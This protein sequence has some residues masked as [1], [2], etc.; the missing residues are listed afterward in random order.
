M[1]AVHVTSKAKHKN[2]E[3]EMHSFP[4]MPILP[5]HR[6]VFKKP[7]WLIIEQGRSKAQVFADLHKELVQRRAAFNSVLLN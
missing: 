6:R 3:R 7:H 5:L 2:C 4:T 1:E